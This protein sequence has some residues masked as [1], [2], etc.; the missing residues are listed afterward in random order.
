V[1][2]VAEGTG[3]SR[4]RRAL[5]GAGAHLA[6]A[7]VSLVVA[8]IGLRLINFRDLRD[9][10]R[11]GYEKVFRYDAE[12]GWSPVPNSVGQ[13]FGS[14]TINIQH[15]SLG[16][17]DVEPGPPSPHTVLVIGDSLTWGYDVEA[18]DR[19]TE[20]LRRDLASVRIVNA[21]V[22]GYGTDQEY[23]LLQ[24]IWSALAPD[25]VVLIFCTSN[26]RDDNSTNR[27]YGGY[28]K[29]YFAQAA[30]G[31]WGF[32]GQP[33]PWSRFTYFNENA[34]VH[35][36]WLARVAVAAYAQVR[37]PAVSVP[38]PTERLVGMVSEWVESHGGKFLVGMQDHEP[39]LEAFL[40][41]QG[42]HY[43]TMDGAQSYDGM[44]WTPSGH[45]VVASRLKALLVSAGVIDPSQVSAN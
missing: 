27:R 39:Q 29:P 1:G 18:S 21:G 38:D 11:A 15:N 2:E 42:I 3:A 45:A 23:L 9:G 10:Y 35:N 14:R 20:L 16:L 41:G 43:T 40:Q 37:Y 24:R 17:R 12:L 13:F 33:V 25:V 44:H 34:L 4:R 26:D 31:Q 8:E 22:P 7:L 5:A 28:L 6:V 19:F 32:R 30:D 36:V